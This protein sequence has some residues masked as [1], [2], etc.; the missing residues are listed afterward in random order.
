MSEYKTILITGAASGIGRSVAEKYLATG[1]SVGVCGRNAEQLQAIYAKH[2]NAHGIVFDTTDKDSAHNAINNF[3]TNAGRLD[4]AILNAG[5]H[6]PTDGL[7]FDADGYGRLMAVNY[8]GALNCLGPLINAMRMQPKT[9][10]KRGTI[11]IMGSVAGYTGLTN[12]GAYCASKSAVMR[13]AETLRVELAAADI[14]V[15]LIS[16]G[17][18]KTPLTEKNDF[19]MPFLMELEDATDRIVKGLSKSGFEI[20]FPRRLAL[21]LR[22]LSSLPKP[23]YFA[24][25]K[26]MLPTDRLAKG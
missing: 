20:A 16:P 6:K 11:A 26:K 17:F 15:R 22:F 19:P 10:K 2:Q 23:L 7:S 5:D 1:A 25:L 4:L 14:D 3:L 13:L 8:G 24:V 18:V 12:A 9:R 21:A